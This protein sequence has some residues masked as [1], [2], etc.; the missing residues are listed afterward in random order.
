[1]VVIRNLLSA[2]FAIFFLASCDSSKYFD[3]NLSLPGDAWPMDEA[4][5]F[6]VNIDDT[7]S[8]YRFFINVRNSTSY[9]YNNIYFFLTTTYP[10]GGMSR[11]T[12]ECM[13]AARDGS[14]LGRGSGKYRDSRIPIRTQIRFPRKGEYVLRLNQ[15]MREE[16]LPGISEAGI[17]LEKE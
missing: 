4:L 14:W 16:I 11:D 9:K 3:E 13:L 8:T 12:I 5:T 2:V 15:A 6:N 17:R 10:G 7:V 1:M